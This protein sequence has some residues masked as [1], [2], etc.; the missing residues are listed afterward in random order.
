VCFPRSWDKI[1]EWRQVPN[2][3]EESG[4]IKGY[5]FNFIIFSY[6][7]PHILGGVIFEFERMYH[8]IAYMI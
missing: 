6:H 3:W 4:H 2:V 5:F 7:F 8:T 1:Q